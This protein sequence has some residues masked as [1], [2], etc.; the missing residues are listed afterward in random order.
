MR[1]NPGQFKDFN[2]AAADLLT[3]V[4]PKKTGANTWGIELELKPTKYQT[5]TSKITNTAGVSVGE[6]SSEV[7]FSDFGITFKGLFRTDK[8]TLEASWKVS[9]KIPVDG[10][11]AK[12]H[13]D[14]TSSSQT[15]GLSVA[16]EHKWLT[17][18]SRVYVPVSAQLLDFARE[19]GPQDTLIDVDLVLRHPDYKFVLGG[20]TKASFPTQGERR[21]DE[22][23]VSLGYRDGKLFAPSITYAQ[24]AAAADRKETRTV[25]AVVVSQPAETQYVAQ[26]DYE[27]GSKKTVATV[28]FSYP[29]NDGAILKAKLN[30]DKEAGLGYTKQVSASTK[31][32]FGTLFRINADKAVSVDAAFAFNLKFTQ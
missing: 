5:F 17:L 26:V 28:G 20:S 4:F 18:N 23:V 1:G 25:S 6:A 27:L 12:V 29:L 14:A 10:L 31:L 15:A 30:S 2:K 16:Y 9:D 24:R 8:P 13:F 7:N 21:L 11:S 22:S 19:I 32:D 3:K